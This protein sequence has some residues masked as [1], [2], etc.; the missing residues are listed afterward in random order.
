MT[1]VVLRRSP[2]SGAWTVQG[3]LEA[4]L[5]AQGRAQAL[6]VARAVIAKDP[7]AL[8]W[9]CRVVSAVT[10]T[11]PLPLTELEL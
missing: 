9:V 3:T 5:V 1:F 7:E 8:C 10:L 4:P 11:D 2:L 6:D